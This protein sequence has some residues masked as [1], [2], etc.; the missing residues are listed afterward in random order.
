MKTIEKLIQKKDEI[1]KSNALRGFWEK[2]ETED[3]DERIMLIIT[4]LSEAVDAHRVNKFYNNENDFIFSEKYQ[5]TC[6]KDNENAERVANLTDKNKCPIKPYLYPLLFEKFV[7]DTV[8]DEIADATIRIL[9]Y[10]GGFKVEVFERDFR[11]VSTGNFAADVLYITKL[12]CRA[13]EGSAHCDFGY[14]L[15]AIIK[16]CEWY[17]I[18]LLKHVEAKFIYNKTRAYKHGKEY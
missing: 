1:F 14:V 10:C 16:F 12:V 13:G 3:K 6:N 5:C 17:Q 2:G 7:K 9:D 8:E 4:E 18:D 11:K 15:A